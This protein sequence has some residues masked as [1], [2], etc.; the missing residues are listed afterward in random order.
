L[1]GKKLEGLPFIR[2][3]N[4]AGRFFGLVTKHAYERQTDGQMDGQ[5]D[6][7]NYDSQDRA[8]TAASRGKNGLTKSTISVSG[9]KSTSDMLPEALVNPESSQRHSGVVVDFVCSHQTLKHLHAA[10]PSTT[11]H[12]WSLLVKIMVITGHYWSK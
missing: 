1:G 4:I 10:Q 11:G 2:Y 7:Q 9:E 8:S 12:C 6:G 3:K 5:T